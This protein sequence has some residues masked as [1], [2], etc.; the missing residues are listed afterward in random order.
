M[1]GDAAAR[2]GTS[3]D[4]P[5]LG[6]GQ[7][8]WKGY[9]PDPHGRLPALRRAPARG[10]P[11][12][13]V[14]WNSKQA[15]DWAAADDHYAYGS[16]QR[17]Q[18]IADRSRPA[19]RA[20]EDHDRAARPGDGGTRHPGH[21]RLPPAADDPQGA[22]QAEVAELRERAGPLRDWHAA[23]AHRRDLDSDGVDDER[24]RSS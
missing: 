13:L 20:E 8:D 10:R 14:S 1:S 17:M 5:I 2:E 21:P 22:R 15:P 24:R 11:A 16:L 9:N 12:H 6:T 18:M 4:F 7:Y 19:T 3:P 23:G